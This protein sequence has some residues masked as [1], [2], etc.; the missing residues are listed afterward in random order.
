M[1]IYGM[2]RYPSIK[3]NMISLI[4]IPSTIPG[5]YD[6]SVGGFDE[7]KPKNWKGTRVRIQ[8]KCDASQDYGRRLEKARRRAEKKYRGAEVFVIPKF[9]S[10]YE[11]DI[12]ISYNTTDKKRIKDY[13]RTTPSNSRRF[14]LHLIEYMSAKL[15]PFEGGLRTDSKVKFLKMSGDNFLS[16]KT[17]E[18]DP[19]AK[20]ITLIQGVNKDRNSKSN[21]AGK[22]SLT[23]LIPVSFFGRTFKD[24]K[25]DSWSNRWVPKE[26]AYADITC[27][28]DNKVIRIQRGRRPPLLRMWVNGKEQSSGMKTT[29]RNGTQLQIEKVTG[30]TWQTLANALY[31]DRTVADAFLSGTKKQRTDVLARFQNLE[32]FEQALDSVREDSKKTKTKLEKYEGKLEYDRRTLIEVKTGLDAID[33]IDKEQFNIVRREIKTAK[34]HLKN[35]TNKD[36]YSK[37][38][39]KEKS[40]SKAYAKACLSLGSVQKKYNTVSNDLRNAQ[41]DVHKWES[42]RDK[43]KCP[44]CEQS[45]SRRSRFKVYKLKKRLKSL[46]IKSA[47]AQRLETK[48][49][50]LTANL[51][52]DND[53][54]QMKLSKLDEEKFGLRLKIAVSRRRY[55]DLEENTHNTRVIIMKQKR[56]IK[57]IKSDIRSAKKYIKS[58]K[59]DLRIYDIAIEAFSRDGIPALINRQLCPVLNKAAAYYAELFSDSEVNV[60]FVV[61]KGEFI[62]KVI[63]IKGGEEIYDQSTGERA[64]AGLIASF[65]LRE[66]A[67][68]CNLLILDEPAEGLDADTAKQFARSLQ[69]LVKRF[70]AIWVCSHNTHILS[71]LSNERIITV[72]KHNKISRVA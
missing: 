21:G 46:T 39:K 9:S 7:A 54:L 67:P 25:H 38:S 18:L 28:V 69:T 2:P 48:Y 31:I 19:T 11:S 44:M 60:Q 51:E 32:R 49:R 15:A 30:F 37:Y 50:D 35:W 65:A 68:S 72:K 47:K 24:Q 3:R 36:L 14:R 13:I 16:F 58:C 66:V 17:L 53:T 56:K 33:S 6:P 40:I 55:D 20:G 70:K 71:E 64:L 59:R 63:N 34:R 23:Q 29:D 8:V 4:S 61:S 43:G 42:L 5:W 52:A 12:S 26:P 57:S 27:K 41:R 62:P 22:S 1:V 10:N 45:V